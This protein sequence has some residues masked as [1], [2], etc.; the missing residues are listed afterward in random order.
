MTSTTLLTPHQARVLALLSYGLM[1]KQVARA[2]RISNETVAFHLKR[3]KARLGARTRAEA[4]AIAI[5]QGLIQ[6]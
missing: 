4:V 1:N 5:R 6:S 3:A 2:M